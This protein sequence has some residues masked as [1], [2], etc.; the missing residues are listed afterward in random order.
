MI[1]KKLDTKNEIKMVLELS[2]DS[3]DSDNVRFMN[4]EK[5]IGFGYRGKSDGRIH[6][7]RCPKCEKENY[8]LAAAQGPC[9][10]C[11]FDPNL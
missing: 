3:H 9:S 2:P 11:G 4:G 1:N 10:F 8:I 5:Q 7:Q 6:I